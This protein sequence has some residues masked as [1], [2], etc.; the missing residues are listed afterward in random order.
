MFR[1]KLAVDHG[2]LFL[3]EQE[4]MHPFW[5][6]NTPIG[7]DIL[8]IDKESRIVFITQKTRPLSEALIT[9]PQ[10][11]RAAL[12]VNSGLAERFQIKAGDRVSFD[13]TVSK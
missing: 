3:Y 13:S 1:N 12:E 7:L 6:K 5:M 4:V 9:S 10:P 8:F 2:M 11:Y